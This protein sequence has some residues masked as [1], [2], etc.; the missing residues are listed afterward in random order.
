MSKVNY[1]KESAKEYIENKRVDELFEDIMSAIC[2][3]KPESIETF[4]L[5]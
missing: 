2:Y 5:K 4:I 1:K 3:A